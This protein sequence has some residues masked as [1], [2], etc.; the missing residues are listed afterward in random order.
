MRC[1]NG[2]SFRDKD[3]DITWLYG[4]W[5]Q[6]TSRRP[7]TPCSGSQ[8]NAISLPNSP[9]K[10]AL[11]KTSQQF[12]Q[13][14]VAHINFCLQES[15]A[16]QTASLPDHTCSKDVKKSTSGKMLS[17]LVR[18]ATRCVKFAFGNG[19]AQGLSLKS[20]IRFDAEV[21]QCVVVSSSER[22]SRFRECDNR[23]QVQVID[24]HLELPRY[25]D[26][27]KSEICHHDWTL[28][29]SI[30]YLPPTSL[31]RPVECYATLP[32]YAC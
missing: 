5:Q 10:S 30:E 32:N 7:N 21:R 4:P 29:P 27:S 13:S 12:S 8:R 20:R 14:A 16:L 19:S 17:H 23:W 26:F 22:K 15:P 24:D 31:K 18:S 9:K 11:K 25:D 1:A 2:L 3:S 6:S 28:H